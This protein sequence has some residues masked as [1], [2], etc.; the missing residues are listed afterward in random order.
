MILDEE[1]QILEKLGLTS[2]QA[3]VYL[4]MF[5]LGNP[6]AKALYKDVKIA[7]Q[8]TY[9]ILSELEEVGLVERII[10]KPTRFR[11]TPIKNALSILLDQ[12]YD[13]ASRLRRQ[14]IEVFANSKKWTKTRY[15]MPFDNRFEIRKVY[16]NDPRVKAAFASAKNEIRLLEKEISWPIFSSFAGDMMNTVSRGV[17]IMVLTE[18]ATKQQK[19]PEFIEALEKHNSFKMRFVQSLVPTRIVTFDFK[20]VAIWYVQTAKSHEQSKPQALWSTHRGLVELATNYF[21]V[22]WKQAAD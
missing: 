22:L 5:G 16:Q 3:T 11:P 12:K 19:M 13:E 7:R 8:D 6:T 9:R 20:E 14:V 15:K 21:D 18:E 4:A 17:K 10:A 2:S 1:K